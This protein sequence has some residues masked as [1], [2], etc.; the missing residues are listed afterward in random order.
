MPAQAGI[1]CSLSL[2]NPLRTLLR[3]QANYAQSS[4]K[5]REKSRP[6]TR[7]VLSAVEGF[8]ASGSE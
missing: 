6:Q 4:D 5:L 2:G 1:Q 7:P 8:F 3:Q